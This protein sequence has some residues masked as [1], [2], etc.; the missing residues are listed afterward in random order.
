MKIKSHKITEK[1]LAAWWIRHCL[2]SGKLHYVDVYLTNKQHEEV[3]RHINNLTDNLRS[4]V[5]KIIDGKE[6][7]IEGFIEEK[8]IKGERKKWMN[9][10]NANLEGDE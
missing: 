5:A 1:Q 7:E 2:E 9:E 6:G 3:C 8:R 10:M 4:R